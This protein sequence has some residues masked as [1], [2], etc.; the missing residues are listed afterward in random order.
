MESGMTTYPG[1]P[2]P[3]VAEHLTREASRERYAAGT[4]FSIGR[5]EMVANT[6][7]YIDAPFHR[8]E[9]GA[10]IAGLSLDRVAGV[11]GLLVDARG[12]GRSLGPEIFDKAAVEDR[13]VLIWTGWDIHWR[14][15]EYGSGTHP[16]LTREAAAH[17][18][19]SRARLVGID[20][21]NIDDTADQTRPAHT[22]L[23]DAGIP[24]VEH[25]TNLASLGFGSPPFRFFAVPAPVRAIGSFPVRAFALPA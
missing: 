13:A 20:S 6:G 23:L 15:P 18:A 12:K 19:A 4:T 9:G 24:I 17:L 11:A 2:A 14:T 3:L 8:F 22:L 16:F 7:T 21:L 25:L 1:L 5:I 10:D